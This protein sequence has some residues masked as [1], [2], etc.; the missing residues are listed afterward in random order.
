MIGVACE[1]PAEA[2][3][4]LL[5]PS[6]LKMLPSLGEQ[7]ANVNSMT[8]GSWPAK[9]ACAITTLFASAASLFPVHPRFPG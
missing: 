9:V 2:G 7:L 3:F 6:R 8:V 4:G 1:E 5:Q